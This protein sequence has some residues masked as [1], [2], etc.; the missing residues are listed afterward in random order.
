MGFPQHTNRRLSSAPIARSRKPWPPGARGCPDRHRSIPP[1][2]LDIRGLR[3]YGLMNT[4]FRTHDA[5]TG[6]TVCLDRNSMRAPACP[7][8]EKAATWRHQSGD[9]SLSNAFRVVS[10]KTFSIQ[11]RRRS[12]ALERPE[13]GGL[14]LYGIA[15]QTRCASSVVR[16]MNSTLS[17]SGSQSFWRFRHT[18]IQKSARPVIGRFENQ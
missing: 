10:P 5:P 17:I 11:V 1:R 18:S 9:G 13:G 14:R 7:A 6:V 2:R 3:F 4:G 12:D 15:S 8:L 16:T